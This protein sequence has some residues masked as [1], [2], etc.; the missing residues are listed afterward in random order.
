MTNLTPDAL[1]AML[2]NP[3]TVKQIKAANITLTEDQVVTLIAAAARG[4]RLKWA[5]DQWIK[6]SKELQNGVT[7]ERAQDM[8]L[9]SS[10]L[11]AALRAYEMN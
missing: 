3:P 6:L 5:V 10:A 7:Q 11:G 1:N 2:R 4:E 9:A 8:A